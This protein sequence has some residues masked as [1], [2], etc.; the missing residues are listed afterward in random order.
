[1]KI[2]TKLLLTYFLLI[3]SIFLL[4]SLSFRFISQSY[5]IHETEAQLQKEAKVVSQLLG[6]SVLSSATV[7][8]RLTNRKALAVSERLMSSKL[9]IW[10]SEREVIYTDLNDPALIDMKFGQGNRRKFVFETV[11]ISNKNGKTL[12]YVTLVA[13]LEEL[14]EVNKLMRR[15]Q[16]ISLAISGLIAVVLGLF[17]KRELTRPIQRLA[18]HMKHFSLKVR[19]DE[20]DLQSRDEIGELAESFNLLSH[21]LRQYDEDQKL[22]FQNASHELK[23]PLMAIQGNAEGIL[24]G[25]VVGENV[26]RS[27]NVIIVESQ[28]LK[29]IVEGI[30]YL[31]RLE[32]M[33]DSFRFGVTSLEEVIRAAIQSV[34]VVA[35]QRGINIV[36]DNQLMG[37]VTLDKEKLTRALINLLGNAI[38]Y[39]ETAVL[40]KCYH[41]NKKMMIEIIDDGQGFSPGEEEKVFNRFYSGEAGGS[42]IGLAITKAIIE[43]HGGSIMAYNGEIEGAVFKTSIPM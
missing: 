2:G 14:Q 4:T 19:T 32:G 43:G 15:S 5:L 6:K 26:E 39:A 23:T 30:T 24:D 22:F 37:K 1:M 13:H 35:D 3:I 12:G 27:L 17:F 40:V 29:Q 10:S 28:R 38:R 42:G 41:E 9:I 34:M 31:A 18:E 8:D 25:V 36:I 7:K 33:E 11:T 20:I 16:L 21:K